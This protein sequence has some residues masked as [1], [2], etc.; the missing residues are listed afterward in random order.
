VQWL[1]IPSEINGDNLN[2]IRY[3]AIR[4]FRNKNRDYL[5]DK[6]NELATSNKTKN[7]RELYKNT[8]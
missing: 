3:K 5:K 6:M 8:R 1:L 7:I 4:H 2:N